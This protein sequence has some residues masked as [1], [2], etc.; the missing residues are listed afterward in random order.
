MEVDEQGSS[1]NEEI[2]DFA[3]EPS[4]LQ[5]QQDVSMESVKTGQSGRRPLPQ[6]WSRIIRVDN[7]AGKDIQVYPIQ[8]DLEA[9]ANE[10]LGS[11]SRRTKGWKPLFFA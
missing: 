2:L 3:D 4:F 9:A 8:P 5:D 6:R 1:E 10:R 11:Q 7:D